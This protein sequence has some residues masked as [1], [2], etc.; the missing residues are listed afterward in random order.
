MRYL[1]F[2]IGAVCAYGAIYGAARVA[3]MA[4][5]AEKMAYMKRVAKELR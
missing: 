5:F 1:Y 2:L 4:F 3:A